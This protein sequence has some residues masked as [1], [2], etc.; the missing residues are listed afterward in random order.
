MTTRQG[1]VRGGAKRETRAAEAGAV[2]VA[3][4][5]SVSVSAAVA[6]LATISR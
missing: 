2:A 1:D 6:L 5:V 4:T 3:G